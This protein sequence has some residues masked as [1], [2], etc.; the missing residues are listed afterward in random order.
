MKLTIR[1]KKDFY[2]GLLFILFGLLAMLIAWNYPMGTTGR[3]GPGYFPT[4]LGSLLFL[5]GLIIAGRSF[6]LQWEAAKPWAFRPLLLILGAVVAFA[7]LVEPLGL[8]IATVLLVAG[9]SLANPEFRVKEILVLVL[10]LIGM[11]IG[12]FRYILGLPLNIWVA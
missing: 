10:L 4:L 1:N 8:L 12:I 5:L 11:A 3:M 7:L 2:S 9:S 6:L